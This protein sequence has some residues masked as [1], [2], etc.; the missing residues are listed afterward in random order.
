MHNVRIYKGYFTL[1]L[2]EVFFITKDWGFP[3]KSLSVGDID[4]ESGDKIKIFVY[5]QTSSF[6]NET[7]YY[8]FLDENNLSSFLSLIKN[9]VSV[10]IAAKI[11]NS[12]EGDHTLQD[13]AETKN[14]AALTAIQGVGKKTATKI[15]SVLEKLF[16]PKVLLIDE[17]LEQLIG[18]G[19]SKKEAR[20]MMSNNPIKA[21]EDYGEYLK[22][23]IIE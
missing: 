20:L 6:N 12:L 7:S 19:Y 21:D 2:N 4:F 22:R 8:G 15:L 1:L 13:I 23:L 10:A 18:L 9:D 11:V 17:I 16:E 14:E 3:I 5:E